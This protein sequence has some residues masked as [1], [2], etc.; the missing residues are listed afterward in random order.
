MD[1]IVLNKFLVIQKCKNSGMLYKANIE[2]V[3]GSIEFLSNFGWKINL[4]KIT[5]NFKNTIFNSFQ[6]GFNNEYDGVYE[7]D[8]HY[9]DGKQVWPLKNYYLSQVSLVES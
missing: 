2:L 5:Y 3:I 1:Q 8:H 9:S 4:S 6:Q 7:F